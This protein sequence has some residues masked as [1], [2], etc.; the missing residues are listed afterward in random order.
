[1]TSASIQWVGILSDREIAELRNAVNTSGSQVTPELEANAAAGPDD[2]RADER[3]AWNDAVDRASSQCREFYFSKLAFM[4]PVEAQAAETSSMAT[5][6]AS[7]PPPASTNGRQTIAA[8]G[9]APDGLQG[10]AARTL[11]VPTTIDPAGSGHGTKIDPSC[12]SAVRPTPDQSCQSKSTYL[13]SYLVPLIRKRLMHRSVIDTVIAKAGFQD[14]NVAETMMDNILTV[15]YFPSTDSTSDGVSQAT[16]SSQVTQIKSENA[17]SFLTDTV[18][19]K[20]SLWRGYL[21]TTLPSATYVF[22]LSNDDHVKTVQAPQAL[23]YTA[24]AALASLSAGAYMLEL[25]TAM[26]PYLQWSNDNGPELRVE[27]EAFSWQGFI[28]V[29]ASDTHVFSVD[30]TPYTNGPPPIWV[31]N[32]QKPLLP[33]YAASAGVPASVT[34]CTE[35]LYM[36]ANKLHTLQF[37]DAELSGLQWTSSG[38]PRTSV[39]SS[40]LLSNFAGDRMQ[41]LFTKM[42][43]MALLLNRFTLS[44]NELLYIHTNSNFFAG[45]TLDGLGN[46]TQWIRLSSYVRLRDS[47][48]AKTDQSLLEL[49]GWA[50]SAATETGPEKVLEQ[51][52]AATSWPDATLAQILAQANFLEGTAKDFTDERALL[53]IQQL[54]SLSALIGV[55]PQQLFTWARPLGTGTPDFFRYSIHAGDIQKVARSHFDAESWTEAVRPINNTLRQ[56]QN[57]ALIAYLL[58]QREFTDVNQDVDA[59]SLFE[60]FLIDVQTGPL[61]ETSR[62]KQAIASVQTFIQRCFLG[63]ERDRGVPSDA[64]DYHRWDWMQRYTVWEANRKVFLYPENYIEPSLRDDKTDFFRQLESD[65]LQKNTTQ[66]TVRAAVRS[67]VYSLYGVAN[68]KAVGMYLSYNVLDS[69]QVDKAHVNARTRQTPFRYY[70]TSFTPAQVSPPHPNVGDIGNDHDLDP[71]ANGGGPSGQHRNGIWAGWQVMQVDIPH[72]NTQTASNAGGDAVIG[73]HLALMVFDGR[74]LLFVA[75]MASKTAP[76]NPF[77]GRD[78]YN[79]LSSD[80]AAKATP[81]SRWDISLSWTELRDGK[82]TQ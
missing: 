17:M 5:L 12:S 13:L 7:D 78:D 63:L 54:L 53:R 2:G 1:G 38:L 33:Q 61:V 72:Y 35:P 42:T 36:D 60:F 18:G 44:S 25:P 15:D 55:Q 32:V 67:Y 29:P 8:A 45:L 3:L 9:K 59:D 66:D 56:H 70:Y 65:L 46:V 81:K 16:A 52:R 47:L 20:V 75:Q 82:W 26:K 57:S 34:Y 23:R 79:T 30:A 80:F 19:T 10:L 49:F 77:A 28:S 24:R 62:I 41:A 68:L 51:V 76:A 4:F 64:L 71:T 21:Q 14:R 11:P 58:T 37:P 50:S 73:N 27:S 6:L 69:N 74:L 39:P 22:Y 40:A 48:P 43:K 31:D